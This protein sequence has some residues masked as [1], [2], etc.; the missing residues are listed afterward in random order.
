MGSVDEANGTHQQCS[1]ERVSPEFPTLP[2]CSM[3]G[4]LGLGANEM[5][6]ENTKG[7]LCC[8]CSKVHVTSY[9]DTPTLSICKV[10]L[11]RHF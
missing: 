4:M 1:G 3:L 10:W 8:S 11:V 9:P 6:A 2:V 5:E 7:S